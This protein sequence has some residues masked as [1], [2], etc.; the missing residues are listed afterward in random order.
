MRALVFLRISDG[1]VEKKPINK[2]TK[3]KQTVI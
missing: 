1:L 3:Q 2:Q